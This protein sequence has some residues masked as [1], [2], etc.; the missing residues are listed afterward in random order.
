MDEMGVVSLPLVAGATEL[1]N[2]DVQKLWATAQTD[3]KQYWDDVSGGVLDPSLTQQA[4]MDE[5]EGADQMGVWTKVD[6]A[7]CLRVTGR[8]P[9]GTRWIDTDKGDSMHPK[10][11]SRLVAQEL[12][13]GG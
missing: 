3:G 7:E 5:I 10:P 4:R 11:R 1:N 12:K 8:G 9:I 6:R 13:K 2:V